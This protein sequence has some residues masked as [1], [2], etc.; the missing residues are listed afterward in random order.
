MLIWKKNIHNL[1]NPTAINDSVPLKYIQ[2]NCLFLSDDSVDVNGRK[3]VNV[4]ATVS[5]TDVVNKYYV[6]YSCLKYEKT[7]DNNNYLVINASDHGMIFVKDIGD[8]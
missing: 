4:K 7:G 3:L 6:D 2:D 8:G 5:H 1:G